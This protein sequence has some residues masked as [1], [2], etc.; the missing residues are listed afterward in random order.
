MPELELCSLCGKQVLTSRHSWNKNQILCRACLEVENLER[1]SKRP[2]ISFKESSSKEVSIKSDSIIGKSKKS[3]KNKSYKD[4][5]EI[6][7]TWSSVFK[8]SIGFV[9]FFL[10]IFLGYMMIRSGSERTPYKEPAIL[11]IN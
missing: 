10:L 8:I 6:L 1:P 9:L 4:H 5:A 11:N 3:F 2:K 7:V